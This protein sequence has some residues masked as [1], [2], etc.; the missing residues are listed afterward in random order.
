MNQEI[1]NESRLVCHGESNVSNELCLL[2]R[3]SPM[4]QSS[5]KK[6]E[7]RR[8]LSVEQRGKSQWRWS[9]LSQNTHPG[10]SHVWGFLDTIVRSLLLISPG[11]NGGFQPFRHVLKGQ[12]NTEQAIQELLTLHWWSFLDV[13]AGEACQGLCSPLAGDEYSHSISRGFFYKTTAEYR[14]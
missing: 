5:R 14:I 7:G 10:G 6:A 8:S 3:S 11:P 4:A 12:H 1:Q 2:L 13:N 9:S